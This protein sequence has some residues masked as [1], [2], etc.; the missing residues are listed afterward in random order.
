MAGESCRGGR[1]GGR[2]PSRGVWTRRIARAGRRLDVRRLDQRRRLDEPVRSDP[3]RHVRRRLPTRRPAARRPH[4]LAVPGRVDHAAPST[5]AARAAAAPATRNSPTASRRAGHPA[6]PQRRAA[7]DRDVLRSAPQRHRRRT[8]PLAVPRRDRTVLPL[9]LA[10]RRHGGAGR[11]PVRVR[12]RDGRTRAVVPV[13]HRA[14]RHPRRRGRSRHHDP[15][16]G[17]P[18]AER[19]RVALRLLD[20]ER[21]D[22][23]VPV[24]AVPPPVRLV[25]VDP[26][27]GA[28]PVVFGQRDRRAGPEGPGPPVAELLGRRDVATGRAR[29]PNR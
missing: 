15:G 25:T 26:P 2:A 8:R 7:P 5:A 14:D 10:A 28:R 23:D 19:Q 29:E 17:R 9:V 13:D 18:R 4:A 21:R 24:L 6:R 3:R 27:A 22:V 12:R 11:P 20:H 16:R 1:G